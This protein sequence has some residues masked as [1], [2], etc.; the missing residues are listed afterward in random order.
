MPL[1]SIPLKFPPEQLF[2]F[3]VIDHTALF[4]DLFS[5]DA[6]SNIFHENFIN[7]LGRGSD[8]INGKQF[9]SRAAKELLV[10]SEK[11]KSGKY[12]FAPYLENLKTKGRNKPPRLIGVPTI[13]DRIILLQLNRYLSAIYP[14][15]VPKT[16]ANKYIRTILGE[17][18]ELPADE[19][20]TSGLD[21][22]TFYDSIQRDKLIILLEARISCKNAISLIKHALETPIVP[23]N[24]SKKLHKDYKSIVGIPQGLAISNILSSIYMQEIDEA[25]PKMEVGYFRYV[26]DVLL[27]GTHEKVSLALQSLVIELNSR[28]LSMHPVESAKSHFC[29]LAIPFNYLGYTFKWPLITVREATTERFLQSVAAKFSNYIHTKPKKLGHFKYLTNERLKEVFIAEL[30]EKIT[31]AISE[32]KRYGWVAYFSQITDMQLLHKLDNAINGMFKR[33]ADFENK[34]PTNLK[35]LK[36]AYYEMKFNPAGS[37]VRNYDKIITIPE[38]LKFLADR[39][40]VGPE[41]ALTDE[42]IISRYE[43][44]RNRILSE[45]H[46]DESVLYG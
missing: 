5:Y 41:D 4:V 42:K 36:R 13:R 8:R 27:Y 16:I 22:I 38:K 1:I 12:R 10:A 7:S 15:C 45:M 6:L 20:W 18:S 11:C 17:L 19:T 31:G 2:E 26:D 28:G 9:A 37:Y 14:E 25:M 29:K 44:Y 21:I 30:N 39:G 46:A 33:L 32:N 40:Q 24:G 23:K 35:K 3:G 43:R 34:P